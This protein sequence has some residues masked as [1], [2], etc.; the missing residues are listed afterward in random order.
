M[1][2]DKVHSL[3]LDRLAIVYVRQSTMQQVVRHQESTKLQ[4]GLVDVARRLGWAQDRVLTLDDDLGQSGA[5]AEARLGFQ[6]LLSEVALDHVGIVLGVEMSRLARSNKD[7]HQ[8]LELCA[9]F[10]TLIADLDGLYDPSQYNDRL[11]L[12]LKGTMS[13]AELHIL[14]QRLLQGKLQKA[15]RGELGKPVPSGYLRR[16]SGEV[17]LDP[18]EEVRA[19]IQRIF[20]RF[21]EIGT[22]HGVLRDLVEHNIQIGVRLRIGDR[23]GEL[24]WRRPYRGMLLDIL[25]N[26]IY[27]GTYVYGRRRTDHRR[28][29]PGRAGTGVT[30]LLPQ[31][32]WLV[33][34]RDRFP[35][36][37]SWE[38]YQR[39]QARLDSNRSSRTSRGTV[40]KGPALL[41][42]LIKC[43]RCGRR[44]SVQYTTRDGTAH[45]RYACTHDYSHYGAKQCQSLASRTVNQEISRLVLRAVEPAALEVSLSA[46]R[47]A[48][49]ERK[50]LEDLWQKRLQR[51]S[52]EA[53]R[54]ARQY[55]AVEP[56]NR[57]VARTLEA[58]WEAKIAAER[59]LREDYHRFQQEQA[60]GATAEEAEMIKALATNLP[61]VW[62]ARTTTNEDRKTVLRLLIDHVEVNIEENTEW[63]EFKVHWA[64]GH[65]TEGRIRR[66]VGKLRQL[67][68]HRE[69]LKYIKD[70]RRNGHTAR[71]IAEQLNQRAWR[72]P[73]GDQ[74]TERDVRS[75]IER[76]GLT[77]TPRGTRRPPSEGGTEWWM[78]ELAAELEMPRMTL[79]AWM[80]RGWVRARKLET[81]QSGGKWVILADE[82]ELRRL[83]RLRDEIMSPAPT[84]NQNRRH[85]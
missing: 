67:S 13:E 54:A 38:R 81:P 24:E 41:Q 4:Y 27:A 57:L 51:A 26:A 82:K 65:E 30:P 3:H 18:D 10:G 7:W 43:G 66:P 74:Y 58:A 62:N 36:Y 9:R 71:Q 84:Q 78:R 79:Y 23:I 11:L 14:R 8:L 47:E 1:N 20:D 39:N 68:N 34:L 55:H 64:G 48:Q 61:K 22:V 32:Q 37:I 16:P 70:L 44:M 15:K 5:S 45:G 69:L 46:M 77:S 50:K 31:D 49:Q 83:R 53:E 21:D 76:H 72:K 85:R 60:H 17:V 75:F 19:V 42:G 12:G 2:A 73:H 59:V 52:Y 29:I 33:C 28:K 6:R 35:A 63:L 80:R 25:R 40:R 56:E